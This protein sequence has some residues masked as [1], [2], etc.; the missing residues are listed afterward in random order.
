MST[1]NDDL[2]KEIRAKQDELTASI[3]K[4]KKYLGKPLNDESKQVEYTL[5]EMR[6]D[7]GDRE[8]IS[9]ELEVLMSGRNGM[10]NQ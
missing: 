8:R 4:C 2:D 6:K 7:Y 3:E 5:E 10:P 1:K 9:S